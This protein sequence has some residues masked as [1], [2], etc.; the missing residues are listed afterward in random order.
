MYFVGKFKGGKIRNS[1]HQVSK[2][3]TLH[4]SFLGKMQRGR[5]GKIIM[6]FSQ[7]KASM[8]NSLSGSK[9]GGPGSPPVLRAGTG[10]SLK[11]LQRVEER[12]AQ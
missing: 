4:H 2:Y 8:S 7:W 9:T 12:K 11:L 3:I 6:T 5:G 1:L 10:L